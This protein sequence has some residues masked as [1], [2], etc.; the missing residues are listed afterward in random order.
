MNLCIIRVT[1]KKEQNYICEELVW[2]TWN[3]G[4]LDI[5]QRGFQLK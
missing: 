3:L 4:M 2:L 5:A 1:G